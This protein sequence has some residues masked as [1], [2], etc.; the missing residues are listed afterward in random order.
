VTTAYERALRAIGVVDWGDPLAELLARKIIEV[1]LT[2]IRDAG[3]HLC[4]GDQGNRH[5]T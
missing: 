2:G 1:A 3:R 4:L 5:P